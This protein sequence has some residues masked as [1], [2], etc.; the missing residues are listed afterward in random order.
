MAGDGEPMTSQSE[1]RE[2]NGRGQQFRTD[3][4]VLVPVNSMQSPLEQCSPATAGR[5]L[6]IS[7]AAP[8]QVQNRIEQRG[9]TIDDVGLI[10]LSESEYAYDG[11]LCHTD[12]VSP[13]DLTGLS[14][15]F[16]KAMDSLLSGDWVVFDD[17]ATLTMYVD[18]QDVV[19][20]L[21]HLSQQTSARDVTGLYGVTRSAIDPDLFRVLNQS[22][23]RTLNLQQE[24][25]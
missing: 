8:A 11:A 21:T 6:L 2:Q 19:Q 24:P 1:T 13:G 25:H 12:P 16:V 3:E 23:D 18:D 22:V 17:L 9:I 15:E 14:I 5:I 20:L 4:Q 10:P 7:S